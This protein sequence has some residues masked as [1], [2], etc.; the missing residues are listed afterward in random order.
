[1]GTYPHV[2]TE[3][4]ESTHDSKQHFALSSLTHTNLY[5][6]VPPLTQPNP[7]PIP[8]VSNDAPNSTIVLS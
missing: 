6:L 7:P 1:M 3:I 2:L 4:M 8:E 5:A